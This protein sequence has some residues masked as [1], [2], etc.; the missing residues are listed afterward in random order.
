MDMFNQEYFNYRTEIMHNVDYNKKDG[1]IEHVCIP[2]KHKE[3][4]Y[5]HRDRDDGGRP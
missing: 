5:I 1:Y 3:V 2:T 4:F